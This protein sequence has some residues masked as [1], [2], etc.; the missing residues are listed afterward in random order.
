MQLFER[1]IVMADDFADS[2]ATTGAVNVGGS[3]TG[4]IETTGDVDWIK[5][6]LT[7]GTTYQFDLQGSQT[8]QGTL[9]SGRFGLLDASGQ[10]AVAP[11]DSGGSPH[12]T[13]TA[14]SSGAYFL[15]AQS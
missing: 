13:Y 7:A 5:V 12:F 15:S 9:P 10:H 8:G 6:T 1:E 14:A 3:T 4:S 11:F 2:I